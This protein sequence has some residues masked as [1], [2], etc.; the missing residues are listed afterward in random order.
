MKNKVKF[1]LSNVH[2]AKLEMDA[3]GKPVFGESKKWPGA[4]ALEMDAEGESTPFYADNIVYYTTVSNNGYSGDFESAMIP[5]EFSREIMGEYYDPNGVQIENSLAEPSAFA[6]MFQFEGDQKCTRH[7]LYNCKMTRPGISG[8]TTEDSKEP[9]TDSASLTATPLSGLLE[10]QA[11]TRAKTNPNTASDVYNAWFDK[12]YIPPN[13][14]TPI[15]GSLTVS[16]VVGATDGNTKLTVTP[17]LSVDHVYVYKTGSGLTIPSY[18]EDLF[19]WTSWN[20]TDDI[21][22]THGADLIVAEVTVEGK[23]RKAGITTVVSE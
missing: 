11:I 10:N 19:L 14:A 2:Y 21:P 22:A 13:D 23:A 12:V 4:V 17:P 3:S 1:G 18:D 7:V 8:K 5:D 20:G 15:L 16:S 6:L 9:S